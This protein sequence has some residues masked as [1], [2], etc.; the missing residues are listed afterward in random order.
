VAPKTVLKAGVAGL[1]LA[2]CLGWVLSTKVHSH[3]RRVGDEELRERTEVASLRARSEEIKRLRAGVALVEQKQERL[4]AIKASGV[5]VDNLLAR[6][7]QAFVG[8]TRL[9]ALDV[10]PIPGEAAWAFHATGE[11]GADPL[12]LA[13]DLETLRQRLESFGE[14]GSVDIRLP[15]RIP[16]GS[17]LQF[18]VF[19]RVSAS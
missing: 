19:A 13:T 15:G 6:T 18:Q 2:L 4:G 10:T 3:L 5:A 11:A 9:I 8:H 12:T 16:E 14:F 1:T 17:T 7:A